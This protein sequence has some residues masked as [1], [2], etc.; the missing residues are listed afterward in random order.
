MKPKGSQFTQLPM[1]VPAGDLADNSK[2]IHA[3]ESEYAETDGMSAD[4][5]QRMKVAQSRRPGSENDTQDRVRGNPS[6]PSL[7]QSIEREGVQ[8]PVSLSLE[9]SLDDPEGS[10]PRS[11]TLFDGHHRTFSAA[12]IDPSMEVPVTFEHNLGEV[13]RKGG[14]RDLTMDVD[15][16]SPWGPDPRQG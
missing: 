9:P 12:Q 13:H 14:G 7:Y 11:M 3:E 2:V 5:F 6:V 1:F 8:T 10:G 4:S 16:E 15:Q